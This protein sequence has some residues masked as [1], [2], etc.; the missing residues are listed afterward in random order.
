MENKNT[1]PRYMIVKYDEV[2]AG[3]SPMLVI[4][5]DKGG[6]V[7]RVE[8][9]NVTLYKWYGHAREFTEE[10]LLTIKN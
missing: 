4:G 8:L 1:Y 10:E 2:M 3:G 5:E 7:C 9:V 6:Y